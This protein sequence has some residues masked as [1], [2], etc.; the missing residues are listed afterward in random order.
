MI[1][2]D[3][4]DDKDC[5][6]YRIANMDDVDIPYVEFEERYNYKSIRKRNKTSEF[7]TIV[8]FDKLN[9]V[10]ISKGTDDMRKRLGHKTMKHLAILL[11]RTKRIN[12]YEIFVPH[13]AE[14]W[15]FKTNKEMKKLRRTTTSNLPLSTIY[16]NV[17]F[18]DK[19]RMRIFPETLFTF[20]F[21]EHC[22]K[23]GSDRRYVKIYL[24]GTLK[25]SHPYLCL[26]QQ[27]RATTNIPFDHLRLSIDEIIQYSVKIEII[28]ND[29]SQQ[30][31][32][33]VKY[34]SEDD[35]KQFDP[36]YEHVDS[37]HDSEEDSDD[38]SEDEKSQSSDDEK[39]SFKQKILIKIIEPELKNQD[40]KTSS[41]E[42]HQISKVLDRFLMDRQQASCF[43]Y[44]FHF[45]DDDSRQMRSDNIS[46][47]Y[48][49]IEKELESYL[50]LFKS[51]LRM[52]RNSDRSESFKQFY[53]HHE[54]EKYILTEKNYQLKRLILHLV[55][56]CLSDIKFVYESRGMCDP[57]IFAD[58][59]ALIESR[60]K[61]VKF[62]DIFIEYHTMTTIEDLSKLKDIQDYILT[63][64]KNHIRID[65]NASM[66]SIQNN[67][68]FQ[69]CDIQRT[70]MRKI[71]NWR[72]MNIP[73]RRDPKTIPKS[74][75]EGTISSDNRLFVLIHSLFKDL[76]TSFYF[77]I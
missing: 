68:E 14:S 43:V 58:F 62:I 31:S 25:A 55:F 17:Y 29:Q 39:T 9:A 26:T 77:D 15:Q 53:K 12:R 49:D 19:M 50:E 65:M 73:Q 28:N 46:L 74:V 23:P 67:K 18:S 2:T 52:I 37:D 8:D 10:R 70:N 7:H 54:L 35:M 13:V 40:I 34:D 22:L 71:L 61:L 48:S 6:G 16:Q 69:I 30:Q 60:E 36:K 45:N 5:V 57:K 64:A 47:I 66:V 32:S 75:V 63:L 56:R 44:I 42:Q 41:S 21:V 1:D 51:Y 59:E 33:N 72:R 38:D 11:G 20:L 3:L 76:F 4:N 24:L 27:Y